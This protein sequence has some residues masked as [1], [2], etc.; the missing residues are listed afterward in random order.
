MAD[1]RRGPDSALRLDRVRLSLEINVEGA[2]R[3]MTLRRS[4]YHDKLTLY[5]IYRINCSTDT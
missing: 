4:V 5:Q 2:P 3:S 1:W